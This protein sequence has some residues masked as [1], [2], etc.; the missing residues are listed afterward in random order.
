MEV[1]F[2]FSVLYTDDT[3]F[4]QSADDTSVTRK[5]GSSFTDVRQDDVLRFGIEG[6]G[7]TA[8]VDLSDGHFEVDGA[9]L[10]VGGDYQHFTPET[11]LRLVYFRRNVLAFN[12][13]YVEQ[14]HRVVHY[15]GWQTTIDGKNYQQIIGL[16]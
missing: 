4:E 10:W 2:R 3:V 14:A 12:A 8:L 5:G 9:V 13:E 1:K 11:V 16:E 6:D 15:L 7:R